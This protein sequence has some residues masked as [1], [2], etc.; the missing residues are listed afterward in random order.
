MVTPCE[1]TTVHWLSFR[2]D[3]YQ[4]A[5]ILSVWAPSSHAATQ[6]EF[7]WASEALIDAFGPKL[8]FVS[9]NMDGS[10]E[11]IAVSRS[12]NTRHAQ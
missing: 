4:A 10:F 5:A 11:P 9:G 2:F 7:N 6:Q 8:P 1:V 3:L 12:A